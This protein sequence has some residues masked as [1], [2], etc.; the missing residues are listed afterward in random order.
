M[1]KEALYTIGFLICAGSISAQNFEGIIN[2]NT[3]NA[4]LKEEASVT[5]YLKGDRSRMDIRSS[6]GEHNS[7]YSIISDE[8]G[9]HMV[10]QGHVTDVPQVAMKVDNGAQTLLSETDGETV[11]GYKCVKAVYFD[12]QNQTIYW[13]T[14]DLQ[15]SFDDIPFVIKRNMPK[16][17]S[18]GFPVKMEKRN[19]KGEVVLS[20][21]VTS[22]TANK[23]DESRF[24]RN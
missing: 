2:L 15:I 13:L 12:G 19:A 8:K 17:N 24:K 14:N 6:A 22:I 7:D 3:T 23:V 10:A 9:M 11:N 16:I 1:L 5:W 20:Q 18:K 4:E 21:I